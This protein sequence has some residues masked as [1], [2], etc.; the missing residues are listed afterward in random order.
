MTVETYTIRSLGNGVV[1]S[2]LIFVD[3]I[4]LHSNTSCSSNKTDN[5]NNRQH[6]STAKLVLKLI[7]DIRNR[8]QKS[9]VLKLILDIE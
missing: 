2:S 8:Y 1:I 5:I 9:L 3:V 6:F 4:S 7:L